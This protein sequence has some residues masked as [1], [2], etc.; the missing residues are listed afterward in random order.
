MFDLNLK[1][2]H[3]RRYDPAS[4][5]AGSVVEFIITSGI[6]V[7][8]S[9]TSTYALTNPNTW[10]SGVFVRLVIESGAI[11]AGGGGKGGDAC[12]YY[13]SMNS[14]PRPDE[15]NYL[16]GENGENGGNGILVNYPIMID[17][18]NGTIAGGGGGGGAG[19]VMLLGDD[20]NS[21]YS[22]GGG[23]GA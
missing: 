16:Y 7:S 15:T 21:E 12:W 19:G 2:A 3:D 18:T 5:T 1:D 4:L 20:A 14:P 6:L 22:G 8:G 17:N 23:G 10:P 9:T 11:V 13:K